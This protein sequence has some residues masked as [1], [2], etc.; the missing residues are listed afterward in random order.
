MTSR[1]WEVYDSLENENAS[2]GRRGIF[3][4]S[5]S[6][7]NDELKVLITISLHEKLRN[8]FMECYV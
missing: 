6:E 2:I 1:E 5:R 4:V 8:D 7:N 3:C